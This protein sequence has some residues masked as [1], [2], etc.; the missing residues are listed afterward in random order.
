MHSIMKKTAR[1]IYFIFGVIMPILVGGLHTFVH[2]KELITPEVQELLR[3]E[4]PLM[5]QSELLWN[6]W[7][8]MSFM[9]GTSF[10]IIGLLNLTIFSRLDKHEFP[11]IGAILSMMAY[12]GFV[13]YAGNQFH[14]I[15][16]FYGGIFGLIMMSF[17]LSLSLKKS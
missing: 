13:V 6:T 15:P 3:H 8:L 4:I 9:M 11:P 7:G 14:A 2:F 17:C 16:Q 10:I 5:G 12:L 1:I